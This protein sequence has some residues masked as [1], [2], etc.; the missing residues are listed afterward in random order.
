MKNV[1]VLYHH[2][3]SGAFLSRQQLLDPT[4]IAPNFDSCDIMEMREKRPERARE[5]NE[6]LQSKDRMIQYHHFKHIPPGDGDSKD[7]SHLE[8]WIGKL[9]E[10]LTAKGEKIDAL[11]LPYGAQENSN[12]LRFIREWKARQPDLR[13]MV[14]DPCLSETD[15]ELLHDWHF[16]VANSEAACITNGIREAVITPDNPD[17]TLAPGID[18]VTANLHSDNEEGNLLRQLLDLPPLQEKSHGT[19][20]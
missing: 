13:V 5:Y 17:Y 16:A 11:V 8:H 7:P 19:A 10:E 3:L 14:T 15:P 1:I 12:T 9:E 18:L 20:R 2:N 6:G 4:G